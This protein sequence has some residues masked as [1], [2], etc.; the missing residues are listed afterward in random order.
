MTAISRYGQA[1]GALP[2][3]GFADRNER[4]SLL[5]MASAR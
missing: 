2:V 5:E 1:Q 4:R 3:A